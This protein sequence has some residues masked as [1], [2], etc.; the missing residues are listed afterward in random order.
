MGVR[1]ET[2]NIGRRSRGPGR[3]DGAFGAVRIGDP[4]WRVDAGMEAPVM[5]SVPDGSGKMCKGREQG[6]G[7]GD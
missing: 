5:N 4:G 7:T 6:G 3:A 2:A 1:A